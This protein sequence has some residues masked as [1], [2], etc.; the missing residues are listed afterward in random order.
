MSE[1]RRRPGTQTRLIHDSD[2]LN[3]TPAVTPPIYQTSTFRLATPEEGAELAA[4]TAPAIYYTRYGTPNTKQVERLL[5]GLEGAEAAL[6]AGSGM[7]AIS[8]ALMSN[9]RAGDHVVAQHTHYT[10]A[11]SLLAE[12][13][14]YGVEVTQVD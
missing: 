10:A 7:A 2:E 3:E 1:Q 6:V 11:L 4:E 14:R 13:P 12:L 8:I 5:A 9:L